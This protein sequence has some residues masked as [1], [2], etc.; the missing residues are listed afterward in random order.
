[1]KYIFYSVYIKKFDKKHIKMY[2]E[3]DYNE[4]YSEKIEEATPNIHLQTIS[5]YLNLTNTIIGAG[6]LSIPLV[7][8]ECGIIL[9]IVLILLVLSLA[10]FSFITIIKNSSETDAKSNQ[11]LCE[12]TF[13]NKFIK[14]LFYLTIFGFCYGVLTVYGNVLGRSI[15]LLIGNAV[16][17]P[18]IVIVLVT[19]IMFPL[20]L[21]ADIRFLGFTSAI[22]MFSILFII[23][24]I[25]TRFIT[26]LNSGLI[27]FSKIR[28]FRF[29][30]AQRI[31]FV[32]PILFFSFLAQ[33]N[34]I[35]IYKEF[36]AYVPKRMYMISL[37]SLLTPL[38]IY[39]C[40][41]II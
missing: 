18:V 25:I 36:K 20:S 38:M 7:F 21:F 17:S 30:N 33:F 4:I 27:D 40:V 3:C 10:A 2:N 12:K 41:G 22:A 24:A 11:E 39:L 29:E 23:F 28:Y 5:A 26:N 8:Y 34:V 14:S 16:S 15:N 9:A 31:L 19:T 35:P 37:F 1:M 32:I 6:T 13:D